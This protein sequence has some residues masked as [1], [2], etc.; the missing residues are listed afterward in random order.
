MFECIIKSLSQNR[1][2]THWTNKNLN[3]TKLMNLN[4]VVDLNPWHI[5]SFAPKT[6]IITLRYD[7]KMIKHCVSS[8]AKYKCIKLYA[9][10]AY[11]HCINVDICVSKVCDDIAYTIKIFRCHLKSQTFTNVCIYLVSRRLLMQSLL[12]LKMQWV[13]NQKPNDS[14]LSAFKC[15]KCTCF[16]L[17][18]ALV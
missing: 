4:S 7:T 9:W 6:L 1:N 14:R 11:M 10:R 13:N 17:S 15:T 3:L 2:R 5:C 16:C 18:T 12:Q 8:L